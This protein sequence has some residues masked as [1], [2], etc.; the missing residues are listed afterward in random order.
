MLIGSKLSI[1]D[2]LN[3]VDINKP[4][5]RV[6]VHF[7]LE[8][9]LHL[10]FMLNR[11]GYNPVWISFKYERLS[12]FCM[13]CGRITH[14]AGT[15]IDD[16][17][18]YQ[19]ALRDEMMGMIPLDELEIISPIWARMGQGTGGRGNFG[20]AGNTMGGGS[21]GG[22]R[23]VNNSLGVSL[24]PRMIHT[25]PNWSTLAQL[26]MGNR[27]PLAEYTRWQG[28][29]SGLRTKEF[30]VVVGKLST[31]GQRQEGLSA[32]KIDS[33]GEDHGASTMGQFSKLSL[34]EKGPNIISSDGLKKD[35]NVSNGLVCVGTSKEGPV[36]SV[37]SQDRLSAM[38]RAQDGV[39]N[40]KRGTDDLNPKL[41]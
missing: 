11:E 12:S 5:L 34:I 26:V 25:Q 10:G 39:L 36:S 17:H 19:Y 33:A 28:T 4:Y 29:L 30:V 35:S 14:T 13:I 7:D 38:V 6:K 18:P 24:I 8:T 32:V 21:V 23:R 15:C 40:L 1:I 16:D 3:P 22:V 41:S 2:K 27:G 37:S 31:Q 9:P 20:I